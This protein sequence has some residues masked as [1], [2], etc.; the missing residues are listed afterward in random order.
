MHLLS[1][2]DLHQL[3]QKE[4]LKQA[5]QERLVRQAETY[6]KPQAVYAPILVGLGRRLEEVGQR[7][8]AQYETPTNLGIETQ[9]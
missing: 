8:Q 5:Q 6:Q 2:H 9:P 7:L 4:L 1:N 3:R